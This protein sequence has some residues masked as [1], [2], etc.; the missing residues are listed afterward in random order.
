MKFQRISKDQAENIIV[1]GKGGAFSQIN[2]VDKLTTIYHRIYKDK[3]Y[4]IAEM[5]YN[6]EEDNEVP[7]FY[8]FDKEEVKQ[9]LGT[10]PEKQIKEDLENER[11]SKMS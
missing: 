4:D 8:I 10:D 3:Y 2:L 7:V 9:L 6:D 1:N 11:K 5:I